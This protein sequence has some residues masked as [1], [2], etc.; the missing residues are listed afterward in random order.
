[1]I[2]VK[3]FVCGLISPSFH[4]GP[5]RL[6]MLS[7]QVPYLHYW[8]FWLWSPTLCP[9]ILLHPRFLGFSWGFSLLHTSRSF[10]FLSFSWSSGALY[11]LT[12]HHTWSWPPYPLTFPSSMQVACSLCLPWLFC[13]LLL[14]GIE[15]S[16]LGPSFLFNFFGSVGYIMCIL[17]F[18]TNSHWSV[19][20]YYA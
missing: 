16:S 17:F 14:S 3:N 1:M 9:G 5:V 20:T 13:S 4:G 8:A 19:S 6:W 12:L 2:L 18:M 11:S 7:L 15:A 10:I